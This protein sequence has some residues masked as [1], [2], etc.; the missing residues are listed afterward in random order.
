MEKTSTTKRE[1]CAAVG[2]VA[3]VHLFFWWQY[4]PL[5]HGDLNFYTEPA[6]L[7]AES[8]V[9]AGPGSQHLDL[10]YA[11]GIYFYPPGYTLILAGWIKL[12]GHGV[13]SLLAYTHLTH[14]LY[15][16]AMWLLLREKFNCSRAA[17]A[18]ATLSAFPMFN[19]GR[20]D[21]TSLLLGAAAWLTLPDRFGAGRLC[22]SGVLL[23][24]AVLVSPS[25]GASASVAVAVSYLVRPDQTPKRRLKGVAL[26]S[27]CALLIFL[28]TWAAVL[29]WQDAWAFGPEQ[30]V[31]NL[32]NRGRELNTVALEF[33]HTNYSVA[34][35]LTPLVLL[36]LLPLAT[37]L[38]L[39]RGRLSTTTYGAALSYLGGMA[40]LLLT[41][42]AQ[43]F[44]GSHFSFIARPAFHGALASSGRR[45][46]KIVG[47]TLLC[48]FIPV[49]YYFEKRNFLYLGESLGPAYS[50]VEA[51][52][53]DA[54]AVV[55]TD[56][57]FFPLFYREG[58]TINYEVYRGVNYWERYRAGT[59][60]ATLALLPETNRTAPTSP[61]VIIVSS[62]TLRS[63][64]PPDPELYRVESQTSP[65]SDLNF[66]GKSFPTLPRHPLAP[67]VFYRRERGGVNLMTTP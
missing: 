37:V 41:N 40:F 36:T 55:A 44:S 2:T 52:E 24:L 60:P 34:F 39:G 49:H 42:K 61:D 22:A 15:L 32:R 3:L 58:Q 47:I 67:H 64:G 19:H 21:T 45:P 29:V 56:S 65:V 11:K 31:V 23:G 62:M 25:F 9:I 38:L 5:A 27:G 59:S 7:L 10:T 35:M 17:A 63:F 12:F 48:A 4:Q 1:V 18:L 33:F 20:P 51:I 8:G 6:V 50:R 16:L 46:A 43:F 57:H 54:A 13:R 14:A 28:G 53:P 30:F 66:L 26:L